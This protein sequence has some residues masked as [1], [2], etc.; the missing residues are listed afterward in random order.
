MY[1]RPLT[2]DKIHAI[3]NDIADIGV[4]TAPTTRL[5]KTITGHLWSIDLMV[6]LTF[7]TVLAS[8]IHHW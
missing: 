7:V 1:D 8:V 3:H 4:H 6:I 2:F 5:L